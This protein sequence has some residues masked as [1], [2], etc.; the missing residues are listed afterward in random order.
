MY[1]IVLVIAVVVVNVW[2]AGGSLDAF[3]KAFA[4][5]KAQEIAN[6]KYKNQAPDSSVYDSKSDSDDSVYV[7]SDSVNTVI[8]SLEAVIMVYKAGDRFYKELV[9]LNVFDWIRYKKYLINNKIKPTSQVIIYYQRL[10][11]LLQTECKRLSVI[12]MQQTGNTRVAMHARVRAKK[13][14]VAKITTV[15]QSLVH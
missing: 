7:I 6:E 9:G 2:T 1:K 14:Q 8:D 11:Y 13:N 10:Y 15:L 5:M 3:D 4:E 12:M